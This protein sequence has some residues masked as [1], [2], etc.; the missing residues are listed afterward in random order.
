MFRAEVTDVDYPV[1]DRL[2]RHGADPSIA[3]SRDRRRGLY[4]TGRTRRI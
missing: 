4:A 3:L 2:Q 1:T